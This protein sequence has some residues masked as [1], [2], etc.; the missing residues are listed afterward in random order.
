[1]TQRRIWVTEKRVTGNREVGKLRRKWRISSTSGRKKEDG[2]AS[3]GQ[4]R[5]GNSPGFTSCGVA[6]A[7]SANACTSK[8]EQHKIVH[9]GKPATVLRSP[10]YPHCSIPLKYSVPDHNSGVIESLLL[11]GKARGESGFKSGESK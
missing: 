11:R 4:C 3:H 6:E 9:V 2:L 7:A 5:A 1:M 8:T 10:L